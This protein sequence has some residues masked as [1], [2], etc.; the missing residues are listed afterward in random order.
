MK[1]K[2]KETSSLADGNHAGII[3]K[4]EQVERGEQKFKYIDIHIQPDDAEFEIKYSCP[5]PKT[6][7]NPKSKI[8]KLLQKFVELKEDTEI[9]IQ[10]ILDG[11][12]I[13]FMTMND[14]G[15]SNVVEGSIKKEQ[16]KKEKN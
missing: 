2:V 13:T 5:A 9:D 10:E 4:T 6:N 15:Y 16:P 7:L 14:N 12:R 1:Y 3:T 11:E 8:G